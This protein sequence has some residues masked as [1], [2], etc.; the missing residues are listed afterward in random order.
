MEVARMSIRKT[1]IDPASGKEQTGTVIDIVSAN[2]PMVS[3]KLSNGTEIRIKHS[4][5]EV[6]LLDEKDPNGEPVY[7][8]SA[9]MNIQ[10][11]PASKASE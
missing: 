1:V 10:V 11:Y 5:T 4:I 8:F 2:E 6:V 3:L 9:N 7:N